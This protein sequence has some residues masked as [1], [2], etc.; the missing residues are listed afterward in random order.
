MFSIV[1]ITL[2]NLNYARAPSNI[3]HNN[4][5]HDVKNFTVA[6]QGY[7][8]FPGA[9]LSFLNKSSVRIYLDSHDLIYTF[10]KKANMVDQYIYISILNW[11]AA[12]K[13]LSST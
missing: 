13:A 6:I 12:A 9:Q 7:D 4:S 8:D 10:K 5:F 2:T 1:I 3:P 11:A